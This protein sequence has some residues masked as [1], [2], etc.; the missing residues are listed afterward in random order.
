[1]TVSVHSDLDRCLAWVVLCDYDGWLGEPSPSG[2]QRVLNGAQ[3]RAALTDPSFPC[4]RI[5]GPLDQQEFYGPIV[6]RT[7]R[8][9]LSIKWATAME[10]LHFSLDEAMADLQALMRGWYEVHEL[11]T[12]Q[13]VGDPFSI[14]GD[15]EPDLKGFWRAFAARPGM[16]LGS[17]SGV[18]LQQFLTGMDRG[19]DYLGLPVLPKVRDIVNRIE[20]RSEAAYG[21]RFGAYRVYGQ[22]AQELLGWAGIV[23]HS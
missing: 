23:A 4:W 6:A 12:V 16:F 11:T 19:G 5:F 3:A 10:L 14:N 22:G 7:G 13:M 2:L 21:S 9:S 8:P 20:E 15:G 18:A 17:G 1:M